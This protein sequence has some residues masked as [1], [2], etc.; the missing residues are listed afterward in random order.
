MVTT[1]PVTI[2][3]AA[4]LLGVSSS[5]VR[6]RI[7]SGALQVTETR[8]PQGVVWLVHLP[9]GVRPAD[10]TDTVDTAPVTTT[11]S[12][13]PA[14]EAMV[15][16][17]QTTIGTI[18]GPLV[19]QLDAQRQTIERQADQLVSQAGTIGRLEAENAAL[20]ASPSPQ[21][22]SGAPE[23]QEPPT[24]PPPR[25]EPFPWPIPPHPNWRAFSPWVLMALAIVAVVALLAWPR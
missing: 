9:P 23:S 14:A 12:E 22:G 3:Q 24:E 1:A 11:P 15:S 7:R 21:A 4:A 19:G 16:L 18:L 5:T 8:R 13:P 20:R 10:P 17:I 25:P 2:E 6:R